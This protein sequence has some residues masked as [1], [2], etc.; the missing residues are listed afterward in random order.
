M[1]GFR[2][3]ERPQWLDCVHGAIGAL[4]GAC[5]LDA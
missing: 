2:L 4:D 1:Q 5:D 3:S